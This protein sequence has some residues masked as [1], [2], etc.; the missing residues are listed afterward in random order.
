MTV[1]PYHTFTIMH[2]VS[3]FPG[4]LSYQ[5]LGA[6]II[7]LIL[8]LTLA[9]FGYRKLRSRGESSGSNSGMYGFIEV[10]TALFI[11]IGL[12]TQL[13]ALINIVILVIKLFFK[14]HE[15]KLFSDGINYYVLLLAMAI[16][17]VLTGPGWLAFDLPI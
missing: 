11:I 5:M 1:L 4:L 16:S 13:A 7:R 3:M 10:V 2:V 14:A 6:L 17:V 12:F 8:G 15:G 9:W